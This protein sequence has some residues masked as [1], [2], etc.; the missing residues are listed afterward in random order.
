[1]GESEGKQGESAAMSLENGAQ[2]ILQSE[3]PG[4]GMSCVGFKGLA[5][6]TPAFIAIVHAGSP[7]AA[8]NA[9]ALR[10]ELE[11][12]ILGWDDKV[13]LAEISCG[14]SVPDL[15]GCLASGAS[16][17]KLL[18]LVGDEKTAIAA[19]PSFAPWL[20][21]DPSYAVLPVFPLAAK[22][23]VTKLL[24]EGFHAINVEFWS[25][26][27]AEAVPAVFARSRLTESPRIF[28]SYRQ[29]ESAAL[30]MQLFDA[31][32][33]ENF[34]VFLDH[35]R[36]D[37][38]VNFQVRLTQELGDKAMVLL[39]ESAGILDSEWTTY[40]INV[41]KQCGL[42]IFALHPPGGKEVP[43]VDEAVRVRLKSDFAGG[44]F[45]A[46]TILEPA[47]L[48]AVVDRIKREHDRA[49]V[50]R[51][52]VLRTSFEAALQLAGVSDYSFDE[53]GILHVSRPGPKEYRVWLTP[54]PPE[55]EDF[56]TT[57]L[58]SQVPIRGV[59]I[60]LSRLM[61]PPRV[62]RT[63][64]LAN[65]CQLRLIDEGRLKDAA[66]DIARGVL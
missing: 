32:A 26:S 65:L 23:E 29:K 13:K 66:A 40:E 1:L 16:C 54:R 21:G 4:G 45:S 14:G 17:H 47:A 42:G 62:Q 48:A 43:G 55:L 36:I 64:W 30:A 27:V 6:V 38:G 20:A 22:T 41:A 56:H 49:L 46:K 39:I 37:P 51:R 7:K 12:E 31:L 50:R 53:S 2:V 11:R 63:D 15:E 10:Q 57:H 19:Q 18:V 60:G 3:M 52:R 25:R 24:P 34:D 8:A 44:A 35:Y 33:H 59:V 58:H 28:I 9:D 5:V 61:E